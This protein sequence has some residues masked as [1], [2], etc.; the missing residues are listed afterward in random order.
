MKPLIFS[1]I[2]LFLACCSASQV[3]I[4]T[5]KMIVPGKGTDELHV[6]MTRAEITEL[7]GEPQATDEMGIWLDY[8]EKFGLYFSLDDEQ[9][10]VKIRFSPG[11]RGR[12][13]SRVQIGSRQQDVFNAYGTPA[14]RR[15]TPVEPMGA[16]NRVLYKSPDLSR[17]SY[18]R[19]GL[20]FWFSPQKRVT[21]IAVFMPLPDRRVRIKPAETGE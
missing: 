2:L 20:S 4:H 13:P 8:S 1:L 11:F 19:L 18:N 9:R 14:Q 5:G 7:L 10:V 16:K 15:E 6:G 3:N 12:L 17:I 21:Q